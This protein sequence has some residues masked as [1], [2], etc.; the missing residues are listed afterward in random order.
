MEIELSTRAIL[1]EQTCAIVDHCEFRARCSK[2][3]GGEYCTQFDTANFVNNFWT[4]AAEVR[5]LKSRDMSSSNSSQSCGIEK[6]LMKK[7]LCT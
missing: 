7:P 2:G 1:E 5:T 6:E 3:E 4:Y